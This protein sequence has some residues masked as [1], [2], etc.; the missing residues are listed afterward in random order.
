MG[1]IAAVRTAH[2]CGSDDKRVG[3]LLARRVDEITSVQTGAFE[4]L[5]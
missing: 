5:S 3:S 2:G 1:I 4:R